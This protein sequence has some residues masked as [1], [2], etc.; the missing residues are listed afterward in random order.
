MTLFEFTVKTLN[1]SAFVYLAAC[2]TYFV[3]VAGAGSQ[4]SQTWSK[5][6]STIALVGFVLHTS[7]LLG[8]WYI[9]GLSR[10]PWTNLYESLV[11]FAWGVSAFQVYS[12]RRWKLP[13]LGAIGTPLVFI[14]M[15]MSVMT[16]NK[17]VEPL[18]PALQSYWL[19]IHVVFGMLSYAGFTTAAC[20]AFLHLIRNRVSLSKIGGG[21]AFVTLLS[22][23]VSG[24][25]HAFTTGVFSMA[26]T[27]VRILPDG[28]EVRTADTYREYDDG[29]VIT[30]MEEVP[31]GGLVYLVAAAC[32][33]LS[34]LIFFRGP[35][36]VS[37][38]EPAF[39]LHPLPVG[40]FCVGLFCMIALFVCITAAMQHSTTLTWSSNPYLLTLLAMNFFI[41]MLY[42]AAC[43]R[44]SK[45]LSLLPTAE[46]LDE[47]SYKNILLAF[48]FQTLLLITGAIWAY[49]A[50]GRSWGWDPKETWALITWFTFLIYLHG[51]L[52]LNWKP[53]ALSVLALVGFVVLIFA[54]L[55]VNLVL[56][57]LHSYGSA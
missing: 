32:F 35:R 12:Q 31:G 26:K 44:Y 25:K 27:T 42:L 38:K 43:A 45:F 30:R 16:P 15:G 22:L 33:A 40:L 21:L 53:N 52:L 24:G 17:L 14:L 39:D 23:G 34:S 6:A 5:V 55:G 3:A 48:P 36:R 51:K 54:F 13:L 57:G 2:L 4:R 46:R 11:F 47:L 50:W 9:G 1:T 49:Y 7:G 28:S 20:F 29:P 8:R 41:C 56:S 18:I 19:K 37:K 10:P